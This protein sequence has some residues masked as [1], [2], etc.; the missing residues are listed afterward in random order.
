MLI[1]EMKVV[2][3]EELADKKTGGRESGGPE[4]DREENKAE[5]KH[6]GLFMHASAGLPLAHFI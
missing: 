6:G 2:E 4:A 1:R 3:I 5:R